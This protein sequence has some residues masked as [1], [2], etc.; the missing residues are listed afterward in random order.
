MRS[1]ETPR[2]RAVARTATTARRPR[3]FA[4]LGTGPSGPSMWA[5]PSS[6]MVCMEARSGGDAEATALRRPAVKVGVPDGLGKRLNGRATAEPA[7]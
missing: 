2:A 6:R 3:W 7:F 5:R 1:R 4:R